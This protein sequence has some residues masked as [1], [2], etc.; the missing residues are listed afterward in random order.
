MMIKEEVVNK[1][2]K[3][4]SKFFNSDL[5]YEI[6]VSKRLLFLNDVV[7][8]YSSSQ[9]IWLIDYLNNKNSS[10]ITL[11]IC[12]PGGYTDA[13]FALY[14]II[15][16][17]KAPIHTVCY[18]L[19]ASMAAV[20]LAAGKKRFAT[21]NCR[22]MIHQPSGG[23]Y[24]KASEIDI[25][26]KET[27]RLHNQLIKVLSK[28]TGQSIKQVAKDISGDKWMA[29]EEARKYGIVDKILK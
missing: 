9:L 29:A 3:S 27:K 19:A 21:P 25:R 11:R 6:A 16:S 24:G 5:R 7:D 17:S 15:K 26:A 2:I 10:P 20:L 14:D 23:F 18:G 8:T 13:G 12:S 4:K 1:I 22:I 28:D